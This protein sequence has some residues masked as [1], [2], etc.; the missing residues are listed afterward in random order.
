[1]TGSG[2]SA[3][4]R[5]RV[6]SLRRRAV[7]GLGSGSLLLGIEIFFGRH[8]LAS[9]WR[10]LG[11]A[12]PGW[13]I[14]G[15]SFTLVSMQCFARAQRSMV[16]AVASE[17]SLASLSVR[18]MVRLAYGA[19]ALS[20][21][22]PAG[23]V[24]S[25]LYLLRKLRTWGVP[26]AAAG[27]AL[28]A[29]G[30]MSTLTFAGLLAACGLASGRADAAIGVTA[31]VVLAVLAMVCVRRV[32]G[33]RLSTVVAQLVGRLGRLL[34]RISSTIADPL[35]TASAELA[36]INPR[37]RDWAGT[38]GFAACNWLADLATLLA[39]SHAIPFAGHLSV[40]DVMT[41][42]VAGM[43]ASS[44]AFLPGGFGVIELAMIVALHSGGLPTGTA[45]AVVLLYRL[46]SC[47]FVVAI[48]WLVIA[49][50]GAA[51]STRVG[52]KR[53]RVAPPGSTFATTVADRGLMRY[54]FHGAGPSDG[55][56]NGAVIP[57]PLSWTSA[58]Q[59]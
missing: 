6:N 25:A 1:M 14:A 36:A 55:A 17:D 51:R 29:S 12:R 42:Y 10:A 2:T 48:G 18:R 4:D 19:N 30:V 46:V 11:L 38:A 33:L 7:V 44:I 40:V 5:T 24:I 34:A 35:E 3:P 37:R 50:A 28:V 54:T 20:V 26:Y 32:F 49:I 16:R 45:T 15:I 41:A 52:Q 53:N 27:F 8:E 39:A 22:M 9:A 31:T 58:G 59:P 23:G 56:L 43:T 47:I 57:S 21:T 13:V